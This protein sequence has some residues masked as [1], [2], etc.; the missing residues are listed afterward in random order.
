MKFDF[1]RIIRGKA[2]TKKFRIF[3]CKGRL[4]MVKSLESF[5]FSHN[6]IHRKSKLP[7]YHTAERHAMP[8]RR[9]IRV[10][11]NLSANYPAES[12]SISRKVKISL[13]KG[14]SLLL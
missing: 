6:I 14:L 13:I 7:A 4:S 10:K 3:L 2:C 5:Y 1:P 11:S 12:F 8:F 9:I